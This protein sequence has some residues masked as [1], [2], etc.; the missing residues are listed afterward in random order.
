MEVSR[1]LSCAD[2]GHL[3]QVLQILQSMS[4]DKHFFPSHMQLLHPVMTRGAG[5][6]VRTKSEQIKPPT[7][8]SI[9]MPRFCM[10]GM[11]RNV[12]SGCIT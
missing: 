5:T 4:F 7:F 11:K 10:I 1:L 2:S 9:P 3:L 8:I 6:C 12:K